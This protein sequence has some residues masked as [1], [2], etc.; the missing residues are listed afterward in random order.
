MHTIVL[1]LRGLIRIASPSAQALG[2]S[3]CRPSGTP[4][5]KHRKKRRCSSF[6]NIEGTRFSPVRGEKRIAHRGSG[7]WAFA[8]GQ[9]A[10]EGRHIAAAD[11][12]EIRI[13]KAPSGFARTKVG[14]RGECRP[15]GAWSFRD[16][17]PT[18]S[19]VGYVGSP[20]TGLKCGATC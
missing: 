18:A 3:L 13:S 4:S 1:P 6:G 17:A 12:C 15:F 9:K 14:E 11:A 7:G 5:S 10:P 20:L 8:L 19:A 2:Y 16:Y